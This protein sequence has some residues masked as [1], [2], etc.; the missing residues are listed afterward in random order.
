[1]TA[2]IVEA[3]NLRA[4]PG[5]DYPVVGGLY[6]DAQAP[7]LGRNQSGDWLQLQLPDGPAWIYAPLV[8]TTTPIPDLPQIDPP[9][10]P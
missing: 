1:M 2:V 8:R 5:T 7:L 4:G 3:A 6:Q 9:P 10:D